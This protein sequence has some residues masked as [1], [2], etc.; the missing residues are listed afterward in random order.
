MVDVWYNVR[1]R[2]RVVMN[3]M[4]GRPVARAWSPPIG[5]TAHGGA[6]TR[7]RHTPRLSAISMP[8]RVW[9]V[10]VDVVTELHQCPVTLLI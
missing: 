4:I 2:G 5:E 7:S 6:P 10:L 9:S 3:A 8:H 1:A